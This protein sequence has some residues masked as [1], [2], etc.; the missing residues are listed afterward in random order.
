LVVTKGMTDR[1]DAVFRVTG[2]PTDL[3][4]KNATL[5]LRRRLIPPLQSQPLPDQHFTP[6]LSAEQTCLLRVNQCNQVAH[7]IELDG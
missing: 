6:N 5:R 4:Q 3:L 7:T 2:W 1:L